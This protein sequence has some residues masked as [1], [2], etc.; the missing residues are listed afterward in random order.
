VNTTEPGLLARAVF[1]LAASQY[2]AAT[3]PDGVTFVLPPVAGAP[4]A[5]AKP[6]DTIIFYGIGFGLVTPKHAGRPDRVRRQQPCRDLHG[7][8]WRSPGDGEF[9]T[10][11]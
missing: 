4:T 10:A 1:N 8:D 5:R 6:G 2:V 11:F 9:L 7:Y 3:F